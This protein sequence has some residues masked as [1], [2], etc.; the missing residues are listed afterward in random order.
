MSKTETELFNVLNEQLFDKLITFEEKKRNLISSFIGSDSLDK[1]GSLWPEYAQNSVATL[2]QIATA[3]RLERFEYQETL[4]DNL[5]T[6]KDNPEALTVLTSSRDKSILLEFFARNLS[7]AYNESLISGLFESSFDEAS[8][9]DYSLQIQELAKINIFALGK[10]L[11]IDEQF[12]EIMK[13]LSKL[14]FKVT[15]MQRFESLQKAVKDNELLLEQ[16]I[17]Y[18]RDMAQLYKDGFL[19]ILTEAQGSFWWDDRIL[20]YFI[21]SQANKFYTQAQKLLEDHPFD[22]SLIITIDDDIAYCQADMNLTMGQF[23]LEIA[24]NT[25]IKGDH[26]LACNYFTQACEDLETGFTVL[27]RNISESME[28]SE[29][30]AIIEGNLSY[31]EVFHSLTE[32]SCSITQLTAKNYSRKKIQEKIIALQKAINALSSDIEQY[33]QTEF[34][35]TMSFILDHLLLHLKHEEFTKEQLKE[36][37][38]KGLNRLGA[39][40]KSRLDNSSRTFLELVDKDDHQELE[41]KIAFCKKEIEK[42]QDISISILLLPSYL[43]MRDELVA[44]S[45]VLYDIITSE[46]YRLRGLQESNATKAL[47]LYVKSYISTKKAFSSLEKGQVLDE[48]AAFVKNEYSKA[49]VKSHLKEAAILQTGNQYFF[50]RYL[51]R[52]LPEIL[53]AK[54]LQQ[55]PEN[56]AKLYIEHH[57]SMFNSMIAIWERLMAHYNA[58]MKHRDEHEATAEG[59]INWDYIEKKRHHTEASL[60]F[61]KS[62][63]A[64]VQAQE[65]AIIKKRTQSEKLFRDANKNAGEAATLFSKIIDTLK[66]DVKRI[67]KDLYNFS[68]YCKTQSQKVSQGQQLDDLPIKDF[69]VLIG[70]ISSSF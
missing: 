40:F 31:T 26:R 46:L 62:C 10:E 4:S 3:S 43:P 36:E 65:Y 15:V 67:P 23:F 52:R 55:L 11:Q 20:R 63:Q 2:N 56:I 8:L 45:Q 41:I 17:T 47:C 61:F 30:Q 37:I 38:T 5:Q 42:L 29:L 50:A 49:Y 25:L 39:I 12:L 16:R 7:L 64:F 44:K 58:I 69:V 13:L 32:I 54:Q 9:E 59:I 48:L 33:H 66:G 68:T 53:E 34:M 57:S 60:L 28:K 35:N 19:K 24:L 6:L 22:P 21:L 70:V 1:I 14:N 18:L 27:E 51:L